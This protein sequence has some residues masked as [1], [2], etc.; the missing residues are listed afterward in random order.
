MFDLATVGVVARQ[1]Q[2]PILHQRVKIRRVDFVPGLVPRTKA[3][4]KGAMPVHN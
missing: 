4:R 3:A 2:H 1:I